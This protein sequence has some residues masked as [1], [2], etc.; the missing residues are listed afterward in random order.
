MGE[1]QDCSPKMFLWSYGVSFLGFALRLCQ[2]GS[3][4]S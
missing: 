4:E 3:L 2:V 1:F